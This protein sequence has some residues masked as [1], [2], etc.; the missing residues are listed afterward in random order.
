MLN[1]KLENSFISG[2]DKETLRRTRTERQNYE[3]LSKEFRERI[4]KDLNT[5]ELQ[6][7]SKNSSASLLSIQAMMK[8]QG[9]YLRNI[10]NTLKRLVKINDNFIKALTKNLSLGTKINLGSKASILGSY[11]TDNRKNVIKEAKGYT[12]ISKNISTFTDV[13]KELDKKQKER[14]NDVLAMLGEVP[15]DVSTNITLALDKTLR[16]H[17]MLRRLYGA[18]VKPSMDFGKWTIQGLTNMLG[19]SDLPKM[20]NLTKI[21]SWNTTGKWEREVKINKSLPLQTIVSLLSSIQKQTWLLNNNTLP[22]IEAARRGVVGNKD[23]EDQGGLKKLTSNLGPMWKIGLS[24]FT[25]ANLF[26]KMKPALWLGNILGTNLVLPIANTIFGVA[27]SFLPLV[28]ETLINAPLPFIGTTAAIAQGTA[29]LYAWARR[30]TQKRISDSKARERRLRQARGEMF[31]ADYDSNLITRDMRGTKEIVNESDRAQGW[32]GYV[33]EE[34]NSSILQRGIG[35]YIKNLTRSIFN[36]DALRSE[37]REANRAADVKAAEDFKLEFLKKIGKRGQD[38]VDGII[39]LKRMEDNISA[40]RERV[41]GADLFSV[42]DNARKNARVLEARQN[43]TSIGYRTSSLN[44]DQE[45]LNLL[46]N[47]DLAQALQNEVNEVS[48]EHQRSQERR[49]L[50]RQGFGTIGFDPQVLADIRNHINGIRTALQ[51]Q[52]GGTVFHGLQQSLTQINTNTADLHQDIIN[53][54]L[55]ISNAINDIR[56]RSFMISLGYQQ[57]IRNSINAINTRILTTN[58][59]LR[60]IETALNNLN[61][62]ISGTGNVIENAGFNFTLDNIQNTLNAIETSLTNLNSNFANQIL[63]NTR[64]ANDTHTNLVHISQTARNILDAFNREFPVDTFT[65]KSVLNRISTDLNNLIINSSSNNQFNGLEN[66]IVNAL[67][68]VHLIETYRDAFVDTQERLYGQG[69][70][71]DNRTREIINTT[72]RVVGRQ[73]ITNLWLS[74]IHTLLNDRVPDTSNIQNQS[75]GIIN[76]TGM[77]GRQANQQ[78]Q[79][80]AKQQGSQP[81]IGNTLSRTQNVINTDSLF[82]KMASNIEKIT[83]ILASQFNG[84]KATPTRGTKR[85]FAEGGIVTGPINAV[86]GENGPEA[87][88]PLEGTKAKSWIGN[89]V[90]EYNNYKISHIQD[91]V[92]GQLFTSAFIQDKLSI[93][94][95]DVLVKPL[96]EETGTVLG[97]FGSKMIMYATQT[98][99][100]KTKVGN[101]LY[102]FVD[103][104][105]GLVDKGKKKLNNMW[106]FFKDPLKVLLGSADKPAEL[107]LIGSIIN[108]AI[109]PVLGV[110]LFLLFSSSRFKTALGKFFK[111]MIPN[112]MGKDFLTGL[113]DNFQ[114]LADLMPSLEDKLKSPFADNMSSL[115]RLYTPAA[116]GMDVLELKKHFGNLGTSLGEGNISEAIANGFE[117]LNSLG[118]SSFAVVI[119]KLTGLPYGIASAMYNKASTIVG[120]VTSSKADNLKEQEEMGFF[121]KIGNSYGLPFQA[122]TSW[123]HGDKEGAE[124]AMAAAQSHFDDTGWTNAFTFAP[125]LGRQIGKRI[126][127]AIYDVTGWG[128]DPNKTLAQQY[129]DIEEKYRPEKEKQM[130]NYELLKNRITKYGLKLDNLSPNNQDDLKK[131]AEMRTIIDTLEN[132]ETRENLTG[133]EVEKMR[134]RLAE[135]AGVNERRLSLGGISS[136]ESDNYKKAFSDKFMESDDFK[137]LKISSQDFKKG[138]LTESTGWFT[139]KVISRAQLA[140]SPELEYFELRDWLRQNYGEGYVLALDKA[141]DERKKSYLL[142]WYNWRYADIPLDKY[143]EEPGHALA[144]EIFNDYQIQRKEF[145]KKYINTA[146]TKIETAVKEISKETKI[147]QISAESGLNNLKKPDLAKEISA[148]NGSDTSTLGSISNAVMTGASYVGG[149]LKDAT[150]TGMM[151]ASNM[152]G[153]AKTSLA[154]SLARNAYNIAS[155]MGGTKSTGYC[156]RG[157]KNALMK[158]GIISKYPAG[159]A[160]QMSSVL[161]NDSNFQD[162]TGQFNTKQSLTNAPR[163]SI[164]VW[165]KKSGASKYGHIAVSLGNGKEASDHVRNTIVDNSNRYGGFRVFYPVGKDKNASNGLSFSNIIDT[166]KD[167]YNIASNN[168]SGFNQNYIQPGILQAK[169][170]LNQLKEQ[171]PEAI[172]TVGEKISDGFKNISKD[173]MRK[174]GS[175]LYTKLSEHNFNTDAKE[176]KDWALAKLKEQGIDETSAEAFFRKLKDSDLVK[177]SRNVLSTAWSKT[178]EIGQNTVDYLTDKGNQIAEASNGLLGDIKTYLMSGVSDKLDKLVKLFEEIKTALANKQLPMITNVN[179]VSNSNS[180]STNSSN[181]NVVNNN[182][183]TEDLTREA[184]SLLGDFNS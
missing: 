104:I 90:E 68:N 58:T 166:V 168:I 154:E 148:I 49:R 100:G 1:G 129:A 43:E 82:Y 160:W 143:T 55:A 75:S 146:Q 67:H 125:W 22:N 59:V 136:H 54:S 105:E 123:F 33:R 171:A 134:Y 64:I 91:G 122:L 8:V 120:D 88:L 65:I 139:E 99:L 57:E 179:N 35:S 184:Q 137:R 72:Q 118:R 47:G 147:S 70:F 114:N 92:E 113:N 21:V 41:T 11:A 15:T 56:N 34:L 76:V 18:I 62:Y 126:G 183:E 131:M 132:K 89:L 107:G 31:H 102:G 152:F 127:G 28:G 63:Y 51:A 156:A 182:N 40:L 48:A 142:A 6:S 172:K 180:V 165:N 3:E 110:G 10:D 60:N 167:G 45:F 96:G 149:K 112:I 119:N 26:F 111:E 158:S 69:T 128:E 44:R 17:P 2:Q 29:L 77:L 145:E 101:K 173:N 155:S 42:L 138:R 36:Q 163:G 103:K 14:T 124:K 93:L 61:P 130:S 5:K 151:Y 78:L 115:L 176:F 86:V 84:K 7:L 144:K 170:K 153:T 87:I 71:L 98:A 164:I 181:T 83:N 12:D 85:Y 20:S 121:R 117:G 32:L 81:T 53:A 24:L 4:V 38:V 46:A 95:K 157:V 97:K 23:T 116:I 135:L 30:T 175:E 74:R 94:L 79:S 108:K 66:I 140:K 80:A 109:F 106:A 150:N 19:I 37:R 73:N 161:G 174:F 178:Q 25:Q 141:P 133:Y 39:G 9:S 27:R 52:G 50:S 159:N 169:E 177:N 13:L 16:N 162:I